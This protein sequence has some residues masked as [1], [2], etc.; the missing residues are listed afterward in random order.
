MFHVS[1]I[2]LAIN[3]QGAGLYYLAEIIEEYAS[4]AKKLINLTIGVS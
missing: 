4:H 3:L 1:L 2:D